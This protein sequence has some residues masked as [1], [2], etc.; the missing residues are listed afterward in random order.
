MTA[1][2]RCLYNIPMPRLSQIEGALRSSVFSD[3]QQAIDAHRA[4]GGD[5]I[6]LHIGDT[7]R[8][9]PEAARYEAACAGGQESLYGY[10]TT[11]GLGEL[12][13]AIAASLARSGRALDGATGERH[14]LIGVGATHALSCA[15]RALLDPGD[16]ALI[17]APYW[18]L[19]HGVLHACGARAVEV[20]LTTRLYAD[21]GLD[22]GELFREAATPRTRLLYFITPNNPDGKVL[23]ATHLEQIARFAAERD[24]WVIAD[25]VY[26][27]YAFDLPHTSIARLPGMGDRTVTAFSFSKSHALAG[28]RIG[29]VVA[30]ERVIAAAR[31]ASTHSVFNVP[32]LMQR[33]ALQA[34]E[35]GDAWLAEVRA[36]YLATRDVAAAALA[37]SPARFWAAEG[38]TYLFLDFTHLL[39]GRPL[40]L[41]LEEAVRRGVL[42]APGDAFG[43]DFST[44]ARLC[45]TSVPVPALR[46]G[47]A[48]LR[49][50]MESFERT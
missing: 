45:Y 50:A 28:A 14:V 30:P 44:W 11:T 33:A 26:A 34:L 41:L 42:L 13:A 7:H 47:I 1:A 49:E 23:D 22:A 46:E 20:P 9:P 21:P 31:K 39:R 10:G 2:R 18:P 12:R 27:D 24:L 37:G 19:A 25:E 16:D 29:Y 17:A 15:A 6:P 48:R 36:E 32:V 4:G 3:L 35:G 5:L 38:G 40:R 43:R 8:L